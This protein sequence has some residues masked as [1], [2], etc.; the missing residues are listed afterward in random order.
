MTELER[1]E[2]KIDKS[3]ECWNWTG[4]L[5]YTTHGYGVFGAKSGNALAHR[6][7]YAAFVGEILDGMQVLHRCDN[8]R[9]VRP[10]HLFLGTQKDNMQ[11]MM[12]KGR[13]VRYDRSGTKNPRYRV[14]PETV[15]KI[16]AERATG[17]TIASISGEFGVSL[18]HVGRIVRGEHWT[19]IYR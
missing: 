17:R 14:T 9:C 11:D 8:K 5:N 7:S 2:Q 3:G 10:D 15:A 16:K 12:S 4:A 19:A 18:T 6:Y 13:E 1:F